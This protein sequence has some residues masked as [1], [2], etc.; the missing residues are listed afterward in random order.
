F[1]QGAGYMETITYSLTNEARVNMFVSPDI[2]EEQL[3]PV[4]LSMPMSEDHAYLR[5]SIIPELLGTIAYNRA[6][7]QENIAYYEIGSIFLSEEEK[8]TKQP[9]ENVRLSGVI[10]GDMIDHK[11][12]QE[13]KTVDFYAVKGLMEQLFEYIRIPVTFSQASVQ[14]MHPGR[15]ATIA[16][17]EEVI[18]YMGQVHPRVAKDF[19]SKDTYMFDVNFDR[20]VELYARKEQYVP[21]PKYPAITRDVAFIVDTDIIAG[22]ILQVI[23]EV[24]APLVTEVEVFDVYEGEHLEDGKKSI[25][26]H[27]HYQ[28]P[29][30]TLKDKDVDKLH[31]EIVAKVNDTFHAFVRS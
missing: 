25:A 14:D 4:R 5:L 21:I 7:K 8:I 20:I 28:D 17:G 2:N 1:M 31:K 9:E 10:T 24:G 3:N 11:W 15:C 29:S 16:V 27:L 26:Y 18:G 13:K 23:Q 6:R 12:Q 22:D 30:K 19:D